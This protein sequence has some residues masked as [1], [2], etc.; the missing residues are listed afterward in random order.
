MSD[1]DTSRATAIRILNDRFRQTLQGGNVL[2]TAGIMA[3]GPEVQPRILAAVQTFDA[4]N[5][6]ND[7]WGEHDFGAIDIDGERVFFKIDYYDLTRAM[8]SEDPTDPTKT[9]RVM[10]IM[11]ASEY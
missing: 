1:P 6:D 2:F 5:G 4:F 8:Y 3:L 11:L 9:E 7:P 10:T